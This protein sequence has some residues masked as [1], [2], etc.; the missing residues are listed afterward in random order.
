VKKQFELF[1]SDKKEL[2]SLEN[3]NY[4]Q[5]IQNHLNS[6]KLKILNIEELRPNNNNG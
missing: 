1:S 6:Q 3:K 4:N 5:S 2:V